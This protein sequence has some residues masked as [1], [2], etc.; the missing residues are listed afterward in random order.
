MFQIF[1]FNIKPWTDDRTLHHTSAYKHQLTSL[2]RAKQRK[3]LCCLLK[4][5]IMSVT[6]ANENQHASRRYAVVFFCF[7]DKIYDD[8]PLLHYYY[9]HLTASFPGQPG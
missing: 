7:G 2:W 1:H 8:M 6:D 5:D 3:N 9:N 4:V